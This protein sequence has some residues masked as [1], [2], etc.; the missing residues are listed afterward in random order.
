MYYKHS[1]LRCWLSRNWHRLLIYMQR[2]DRSIQRRLGATEQLKNT[3]IP[4][5]TGNWH[6]FNGEPL[7]SASSKKRALTYWKVNGV[8]RWGRVQVLRQTANHLILLRNA[9]SCFRRGK[10]TRIQ[11]NNRTSWRW[12][13]TFPATQLQKAA[14]LLTKCQLY[15][16]A[17]AVQ[18]YIWVRAA[19]RSNLNMSMAS[20][21][22]WYSHCFLLWHLRWG[23][24]KLLWLQRS[25]PTLQ[26]RVFR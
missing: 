23:W 24:N 5:N 1:T 17:D 14:R 25:W 16:G 20:T 11:K 13:C 2:H 3:S 8:V 15:I 4:G 18:C 9:A 7:S 12:Q 6:I 19:Q 21:D 22:E 10:L 26:K